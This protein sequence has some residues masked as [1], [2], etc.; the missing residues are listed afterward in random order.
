MADRHDVYHYCWRSIST[1]QNTVLFG[2]LLRRC[3]DSEMSQPLISSTKCNYQ[4]KHYPWIHLVITH[5]IAF[6]GNDCFLKKSTWIKILEGCK[7]GNK[8]KGSFLYDVGCGL[9]WREVHQTLSYNPI[10]SSNLSKCLNLRACPALR[11]L[12]ILMLLV[13]GYQIQNA[14]IARE[15]KRTQERRMR[16]EHILCQHLTIFTKNWGIS[17]A[18]IQRRERKLWNLKVK[19]ISIVMSLSRMLLFTSNQCV[20]PN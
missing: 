18:W 14:S 8:R 11:L 20:I 1:W 16:K 4:V 19:M 6:K 5:N 15:E 17:M 13:C 2:G 10:K 3:I 7:F 12:I 9:Q